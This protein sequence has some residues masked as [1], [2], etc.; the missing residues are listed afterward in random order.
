M[1][2]NELHP[3]Q[4][5]LLALLKTNID[6]PLTMKE[7]SELADISSPGVLYYHLRQL[8]KKG[9]LKRNPENPKDYN[10]LDSPEKS[11]VYINKY[12][13]AQCGPDGSLLSGNVLERVPVASSLLRFPASLAFIVESKGDSMEPKISNGDI[14][15]AKRQNYAEPGDLIICVYNERVLLKQLLKVD[16]RVILNS[17][18]KKYNLIE[19]ANE[20]DLRIEG[21]VKN[22]L[23]YD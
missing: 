20:Y 17:F 16:N 11:V 9:V 15:I 22:I 23:H 18:N 7:L 4:I 2:M 3:K 10:I 21:I 12:G 6:M 8:E 13:M 19:V 14:I 1:S 5:R